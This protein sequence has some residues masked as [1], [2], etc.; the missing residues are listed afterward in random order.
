MIFLTGCQE[1]LGRGPHGLKKGK[2]SDVIQAEFVERGIMGHIVRRKLDLTAVMH[3]RY[4]PPFFVSA[5]H[6]LSLDVYHLYSRYR[7]KETHMSSGNLYRGKVEIFSLISFTFC[8]ISP[9]PL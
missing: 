1:L 7:S 3:A 8:D 9:F 4:Y 5:S 6:L 2:V